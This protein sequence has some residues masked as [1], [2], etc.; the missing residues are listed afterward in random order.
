MAMSES[1]PPKRLRAIDSHTEGEPTRVVTDGLPE[2]PGKTMLQKR[3]WL[4]E[5]LDQVRTALIREPRG[6]DAL[7]MAYL[8]PP[9]TEGATTGVVF[10]NSQG[11]LNMCGHGAIGVAQGRFKL[12]GEVLNRWLD[13]LFPMESKRMRRLRHAAALLS[14]IGW[15]KSFKKLDLTRCIG[16]M[17]IPPDDMR[18]VH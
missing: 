6:H 10:T 17:V 13:D 4:R 7:V 14:D 12:H 11:Y 3:E 9:V 1:E 18:D 16:E 2:V 15:R 5:N 8:L